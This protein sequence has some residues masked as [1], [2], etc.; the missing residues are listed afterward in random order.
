MAA[1]DELLIVDSIDAHL[2]GMRKL[3]DDAGYVVTATPRLADAR[4]LLEQKFF[5]V[6]LVDLDVEQPG[7]GLD[8][9]RF[10]HD[11]SRQTSVL[12]LTGRR[13][14]EGAV[15]ALR[16]GVG[17]VVLKQPDAVEHLKRAVEV[18]CDR[19]RAAEGDDL[20]REVQAILDESFQ[21][22][23]ALA[24]EVY[25]DVSV[26]AGAAFTPRILVVDGDGDF[27]QKLA[28]LLQK[29]GWQV[30]AEMAGGAALDKA[31]EHTFDVVAARDELMDLKG[32]M[33]VKSIQAQRAEA[34]GLVYSAPGGEGRLER[35]QEG[36]ALE[37]ERPFQGPE[38]LVRKLREVVAELG[39]T[40]RDRRIIQAFRRDHED[41]LRRYAAL[42][43]RVGRLVD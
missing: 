34:V 42:K 33:V 16:L 18:A 14:Y 36:R 26:G 2:Q 8:L 28:P 3:F 7:A 37:V 30:A 19:F 21:V 20:L 12:L 25:Q 11:R 6:A 23:L 31:G 10:I 43:M 17:D 29:E 35:H 9:V 1:G 38:H 27:L 32:S 5:P 24:R 40:Q 22:M 13:S 41:F 39:A 15:E 4:Q